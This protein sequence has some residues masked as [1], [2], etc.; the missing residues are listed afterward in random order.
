MSITEKMDAL[1]EEVRPILTDV[2]FVVLD[3]LVRHNLS[4]KE[5]AYT[6]HYSPSLVSKRKRSAIDKIHKAMIDETLNDLQENS[7]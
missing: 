7:F 5:I 6:L 2:E 3:N 1:F 4:V